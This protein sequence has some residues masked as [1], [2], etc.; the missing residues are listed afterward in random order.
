[1]VN[2]CDMM[3]IWVHCVFSAVL[4]AMAVWMFL[5]LKFVTA[6]IRVTAT[7]ILVTDYFVDVFTQLNRQ[8]LWV[9][10]LSHWSR[11]FRH[12]L[13][14]CCRPT[15]RTLTSQNCCIGTVTRLVTVFH[16][17]LTGL[18]MTTLCEQFPQYTVRFVSCWNRIEIQSFVKLPDKCW[19][20]MCLTDLANPLCS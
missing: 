3:C 6:V 11:T 5:H 19:T 12:Q 13:G 17:C 9:K 4:F 16:H 2:V 10:S 18:I 15:T 20:T 1:M 7:T 8:N 14:S